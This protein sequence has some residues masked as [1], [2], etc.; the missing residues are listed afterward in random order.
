MKSRRSGLFPAIE[1]ALLCGLA[2]MVS[3][4]TGPVPGHGVATASAAESGPGKTSESAFTF[5]VLGDRTGSAREG[6]FEQVVEDMAFL[7]PDIILTVGDLIQGYEPDSA[8]V[9]S[10][11]DYVL[12]LMES[13][14]IEYH[15]TPGNHDIWS[16]QSLAIY[17]RRVGERNKALSYRD[18][19]FVIFDVSLQYTAGM[20]PDEQLEWLRGALA[21]ARDHDHTFVFYHKPFWCEDFSSDRENLLHELFKENGVDAVFTGH[22]HRQFY[23]ERDGIRYYSVSSSGGGLPRWAAGEGSFYSYMWVRVDGD[24]YEVKTMEPGAGVASDEITMEDMMM[25]DEILG[26]V[27]TMDDITVT[28]PEYRLPEKVTVRIENISE[29]TLTDTARWDI[30]DGWTVDPP[31]DYVEVPPG[32]VA[33][34]SAFISNE[35][36]AFPVPHLSIGVPY[37]DGRAIEVRRPASIKRLIFAGACGG[38]NYSPVSDDGGSSGGRPLLDGV[39]DDE[40]WRTN[41]PEVMGFG[42]AVENA[43]EDSTRIRFCHD[44]SNLYVA[45]EC[46]DSRPDGVSATVRERDG[47]SNPDDT[48]ML[49]FQPDRAVRDFYVISV[50]PLGTVFDRFVEICP[51]GS[52]VIHPEWDAPASTGA[53]IDEQGWTAEIAIPIG[54]IG[55]GA[56]AADPGGPAEIAGDRWGFN[57]SRWHH[58]I[59]A[60]T[61]FQYPVRYDAGYMGVLEFN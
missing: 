6:V 48:F 37:K 19:L 40:I 9:E 8:E 12:E 32:E 44:N 59:E 36:P 5:A 24:A 34:L 1:I 41:P 33:T 13:I 29:T 46:F 25:I 22:Y 58:R 11:W 30:R 18:N 45:V 57:F 28:G 2:V 31:A 54:E 53:R 17:E 42:W 51:F 35:G 55:A 50:N 23:T 26:G 20:M 56:A 14:G 52:Y 3:G 61:Y 7:R 15:L 21:E 39:L 38:G 27:I 49:M 43:P 10:Q 4:L 16:D 47:F 60:S